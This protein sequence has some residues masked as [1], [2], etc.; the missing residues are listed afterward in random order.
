MLAHVRNAPI[1]PSERGEL[2]VPEWLD[3]IILMCLAKDP[4]KRPASAEILTQ[5]LADG[6]DAGS[7]T[8]KNSED[9]WLTNMPENAVA[10][11]AIGEV[12]KSV[13]MP[14]RSSLTL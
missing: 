10:V 1:P 14:P 5:M 3:N 7:W 4:S 9:W 2:P 11:D 13:G 12:T 6:D 8:L